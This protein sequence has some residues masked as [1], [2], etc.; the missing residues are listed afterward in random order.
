M[1]AFWILICSICVGSILL[2][3]HN[4]DEVHLLMAWLSGALGLL[5]ILIL[6]PPLIKGLLGLVFFGV[7]HKIFPVHN[8]FR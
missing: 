4:R 6:T 8:C 2:L 3:I 5:C 7:G 1:L